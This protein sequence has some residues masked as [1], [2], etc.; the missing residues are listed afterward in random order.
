MNKIL[1]GVMILFVISVSP[2]FAQTNPVTVQTDDKNYDEGD[3]IVI[4]GQVATVVPGTPVV[5]QIF[6]EGNMID[7]AQITVAQDGS[8]TQTVIA[9][10]PLWNKTG[11]YL[12]RASYGDGNIAESEFSFTPKTGISKTTNIF[13]V[14]AGRS[15]TFDVEYTIRGGTIN[16]MAVDSDSFSLDV[17]IDSA[18]DGAITLNLPREFIGAEKQ[19]GKDEVF[20][21]L[22]EGIE[23]PY[24]ESVTNSDS[25]TII[26]N[27][28][29]G[30]SNIRIIGTYVIPEFSTIAT[31]ILL[32]GIATTVMLTRNKFQI[33]I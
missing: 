23:V 33:K 1:F 20:I 31:M 15:G 16:D 26:I 17:Q 28:E 3:T 8:Y 10:G 25:R 24:Q 32:A 29:Q 12:I 14:D 9:E 7:I 11:D 5:L 13:E 18:D 27:F 4:S 6:F 30:D 21:V 22:I 19:D 2:V